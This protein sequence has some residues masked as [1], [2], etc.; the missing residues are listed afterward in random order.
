MFHTLSLSLSVL[1]LAVCALPHLRDRP[2]DAT[3]GAGGPVVEPAPFERLRAL[4]RR[5]GRLSVVLPAG[6]PAEAARR[7]AALPD[8]SARLDALAAC[9]ARLSSATRRGRWPQYDVTARAD[10]MRAI[11]ARLRDPTLGLEQRLELYGEFSSYSAAMFSREVAARWL[12]DYWRVEDPA[13]R[14]RMILQGRHMIGWDP[15]IR[16]QLILEVLGDGD[17]G[18]RQ[19]AGMALTRLFGDPRV[20]ELMEALARGAEDTPL[21][22]QGRAYTSRDLWR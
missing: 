18:L 13:R 21:R 20:Q 10:E 6:E 4:E 17:D 8:P 14:K 19:F 7:T 5:L 12:G 2:V 9:L 15:R 3:V 22:R 11:E 16:D 1:A